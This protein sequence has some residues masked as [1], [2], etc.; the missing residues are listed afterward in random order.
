MPHRK[1]E[2]PAYREWIAE[3]LNLHFRDEGCYDNAIHAAEWLQA[4]GW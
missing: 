3:H 2:S 4:E 1:P